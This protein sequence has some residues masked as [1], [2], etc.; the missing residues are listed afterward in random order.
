MTGEKYPLPTFPE[1]HKSLTQLKGFLTKALNSPQRLLVAPLSVLGISSAMDQAIPPQPTPVPVVGEAIRMPGGT[2]ATGSTLFGSLR[3]LLPSDDGVDA[4]N[5]GGLDTRLYPG[6]GIE[7]N[8]NDHELSRENPIYHISNENQYL[9]SLEFTLSRADFNS[10]A[11]HNSQSNNGQFL[12]VRMN[13]IRFDIYR[14]TIIARTRF[15]QDPD[16]YFSAVSAWFVTNQSGAVVYRFEMGESP[17]DEIVSVIVNG[18]YLQMVTRPEGEGWEPPT[19]V[20]PTI[21]LRPESNSMRIIEEVGI[22]DLSFER[23]R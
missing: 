2:D 1:R 5:R 6:L 14:D 12:S 17:S 21:E 16:H 18:R 8:N 23:A 19:N 22:L 7:P 15:Y 10:L 9:R 3:D 4:D 11:D 20:T 13:G